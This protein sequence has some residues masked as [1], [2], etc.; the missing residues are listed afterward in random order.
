MASGLFTTGAKSSIGTTAVQITTSDIKCVFGV[1]VKAAS[2]NTGIVYVGPKGVTAGTADAT[3]GIELR[4]GEEIKIE[5]D[6]A[7]KVY[8]IGSATGQKVFWA[9]V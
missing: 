9:A 7:K 6:N 1:L 8:V 5:V 2:T 4:A 3:D